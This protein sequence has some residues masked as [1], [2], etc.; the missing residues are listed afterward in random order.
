MNARKFVPQKH[1][2]DPRFLLEVH[3]LHLAALSLY[4]AVLP[5]YDPVKYPHNRFAQTRAYCEGILRYCVVSTD[6]NFSAAFVRTVFFFQT[7]A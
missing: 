7:N 6:R 4:P 3:S 1:F 2:I 5:A